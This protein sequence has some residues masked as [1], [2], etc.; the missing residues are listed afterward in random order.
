M[1]AP[2]KADVAAADRLLKAAVKRAREVISSAHTETLRS[3]SGRVI[4]TRRSYDAGYVEA[5]LAAAMHS[6]NLLL[7]A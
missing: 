5:M 1:T 2:T 7:E 6:A 3:A 4:Y